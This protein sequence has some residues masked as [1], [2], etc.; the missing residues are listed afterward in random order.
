MAVSTEFGSLEGS[1]HKPVKASFQ[2]VFDA[3]RSWEG[4]TVSVFIG[5]AT[6]PDGPEGAGM[7]WAK[8]AGVLGLSDE[9]PVWD[10]HGPVDPERG[11]V[12][13]QIGDQ[14]QNYFVIYRSFTT[15]AYWVGPGRVFA[16]LRTHDTEIGI[17]LTKPGPSDL[18]RV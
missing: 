6:L 8:M 10:A 7:V 4:R 16:I 2:E 17:H 11:A 9:G 13:F 3:L 12:A 15:E 1:F 14:T 5:P 18:G